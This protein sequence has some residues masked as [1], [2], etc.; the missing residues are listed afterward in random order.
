MDDWGYNRN[1]FT[2]K[3]HLTKTFPFFK[4]LKPAK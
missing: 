3:T 2:E 4:K 1:K